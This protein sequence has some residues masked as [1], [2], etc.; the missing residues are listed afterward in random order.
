MPTF[1]MK[2]GLLLFKNDFV[3]MIAQSRRCTYKE[4]GRFNMNVDGLDAL[5]NKMSIPASVS[6]LSGHRKP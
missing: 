4:Q 6:H 2:A 1:V 3:M 5:D